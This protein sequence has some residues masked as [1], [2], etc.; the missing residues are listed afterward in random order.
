PPAPAESRASDSSQLGPPIQASAASSGSSQG[1]T[2]SLGLTSPSQPAPPGPPAVAARADVNWG[3]WLA[4]LKRR[5]EGNWI[6][7][8]SGASRRTVVVF[9]VGR[10]GSL[11]NPRISRSSGHQPTDDAA[12]QAISRASPYMALPAEYVGDAVQINFTFDI[13]VL[14]QLEGSGSGI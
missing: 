10:N 2:D 12:L 11:S 4:D 13:N 5:V 6:P 1:T 3:P 14:G 7:G 8:Q 9:S